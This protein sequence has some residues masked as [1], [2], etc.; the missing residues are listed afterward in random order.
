MAAAIRVLASVTRYLE[1]ELK[2]KVNREK[3]KVVR[4]AECP[5]LGYIIGVAGKLRIPKEKVVKFKERIRELTRRNRGGR[6]SEMVSELNAYIR[7][8]G[9]YYKLAPMKATAERLDEWIRRK[10][11]V[12]K[13]KQ[14]KRARTIANFL[15]SEGIG[16]DQ[17]Y[18]IGGSGKGWWR[19]SKTR[20][21]HRAMGKEWFRR[22]GL[23]SLQNVV[24]NV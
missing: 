5:F 20:Q 7:G 12:I 3:S 23:V 17:A 22:Q 19:L 10:V 6:L 4:A 24:C 8:W 13:L 18:M 2:L 1:G 14:C 9:N 11:R 16:K 15:Q 21:T